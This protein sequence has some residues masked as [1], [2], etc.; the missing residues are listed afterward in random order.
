MDVT[1]DGDGGAKVLDVALVDK[2][3]TCFIEK[4][5]EILFIGNL[6]FGKCLDELADVPHKRLSYRGVK[7]SASYKLKCVSCKLLRVHGWPQ[8]DW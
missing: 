3:L 7:D 8:F 2:Q 6:A 1:A 4:W 5:N